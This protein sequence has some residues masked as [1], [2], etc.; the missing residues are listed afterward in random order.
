MSAPIDLGS[1][2]V[3]ALY[4]RYGEGDQVVG[5][6]HSHLKPDGR[7]CSGGS[8]LF[9]IPTNADF[10]GHAKWTLVSLDPLH[11][12][13]SVLCTICGCHGFIRGGKWVEA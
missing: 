10:P 6:I 8:I 5:L 2:H 4:A 12:E 3:A 13:P 9:D 1:G 7:K 11:L